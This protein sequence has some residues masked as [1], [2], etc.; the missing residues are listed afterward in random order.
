MDL[1]LRAATVAWVYC[2]SHRTVVLQVAISSGKYFALLSV[3]YIAWNGV[4]MGK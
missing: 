1:T 3:G 2:E 4:M